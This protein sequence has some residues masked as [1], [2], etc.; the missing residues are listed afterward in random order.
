M[1]KKSWQGLVSVLTSCAGFRIVLTPAGIRVW[2]IQKSSQQRALAAYGGERGSRTPAGFHLCQFSKLV[3]SA[4]W[5]FLRVLFYYT[6]FFSKN[7]ALNEKNAKK[8]LLF[9][10]KQEKRI[11]IKTVK[12][13]FYSKLGKEKRSGRINLHFMLC[14]ACFFVWIF[15]VC[16]K[17]NKNLKEKTII[18]LLFSGSH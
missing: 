1:V 14:P 16:P 11:W 4:T 10:G 5:V 18:F 6:K 13:G 9:T 3:P 8:V 15:Y 12:E 17:P 7:R 2:K